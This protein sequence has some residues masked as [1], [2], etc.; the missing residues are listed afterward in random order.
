MIKMGVGKMGWVEVVV[1]RPAGSQR[2]I[3]QIQNVIH[4]VAAP[5]N[6]L[7]VDEYVPLPHSRANSVLTIYIDPHINNM[8]TIY[9]LSRQATEE[10]YRGGAL[11]VYALAGRRLS[12]ARPTDEADPREN[13][14]RYRRQ[15]STS[16]AP[17]GQVTSPFLT[18]FAHVFVFFF[19]YLFTTAARC[20]RSRESYK[21]G[22]GRRPR[23][24]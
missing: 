15:G 5:V 12:A 20:S 9:I 2:W 4:Q 24:W 16:P 17:R 14:E 10:V 23:R 3:M 1:R 6:T 11:D 8:S 19:I 13:G 7:K 21:C 22:R 18:H